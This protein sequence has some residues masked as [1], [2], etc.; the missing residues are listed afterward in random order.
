MDL[1]GKVL[2]FL[3]AEKFITV[4]TQFTFTLFTYFTVYTYLE[5]QNG[6]Q[7]SHV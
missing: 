7:K 1:Y 4:C 3:K 6:L 2:F 5:S